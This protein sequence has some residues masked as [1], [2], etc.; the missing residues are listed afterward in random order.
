M[1]SLVHT[2]DLLVKNANTHTHTH[3]WETPT[4]L[5]VRYADAVSITEKGDGKVEV[6]LS[7]S[8]SEE[9]LHD[10]QAPVLAKVPQPGLVAYVS[11]LQ[12]HLHRTQGGAG[13]CNITI[14]DCEIHHQL[15]QP[16]LGINLPF[17][18]LTMHNYFTISALH[19]GT[20]SSYSS[21][22]SNATQKVYEYS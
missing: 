10:A 6:P 14:Y 13:H 7:V 15:I 20:L 8:L 11:T 9:L 1:R 21:L 22:I 5:G 12:G 2:S 3:A 17:L 4:F 19:R 16:P 18:L